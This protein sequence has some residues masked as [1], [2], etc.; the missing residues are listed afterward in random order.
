MRIFWMLP[1][2][3]LL[4]C[5][6]K[7]H[8]DSD[9][10]FLTITD[11]HGFKNS[12]KQFAAADNAPSPRSDLPLVANDNFVGLW[13]AEQKY[14]L[15]YMDFGRQHETLVY[16]KTLFTIQKDTE[17]DY[18]ISSCNLKEGGQLLTQA[19]LAL[20]LPVDVALAVQSENALSDVIRVEPQ[21]NIQ[22]NIIP[23]P[24]HGK[25]ITESDVDTIYAG[26]VKISAV[27]EINGLVH[28][29][30]PENTGWFWPLEQESFSE[31]PVCVQWRYM[32]D[33][34]L[35]QQKYRNEYRVVVRTPDNKIN[36][37]FNEYAYPDFNIAESEVAYNTS[38][39]SNGSYWSYSVSLFEGYISS[40]KYAANNKELIMKDD[41]VFYV[42][43][44]D[45][46][47]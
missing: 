7:H 45:V 40:L 4:G 42:A 9:Y 30:V 29:I 23:L 46:H 32:S 41:M 3:L 34:N 1:I 16:E 22:M 35:S 17:G 21:S 13:L 5:N 36:Y 24:K 19:D 18:W 10:P 38:N 31:V 28:F 27:P 8:A 25:N 11:F 15:R 43:D 47:Y 37:Y 39:Y 26:A 44:I 2:V 33:T 12:F 14:V 6:E 20:A